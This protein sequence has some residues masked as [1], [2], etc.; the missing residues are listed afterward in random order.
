MVDY[1]S[2]ETKEAADISKLDFQHIDERINRNGNRY[3]IERATWENL[4][5]TCKERI[6]DEGELIPVNATVRGSLHKWYMGNNAGQFSYQDVCDSI[7]LLTNTLKITPEKCR[8]RAIE[9]AVNIHTTFDV[10]NALK[11]NFIAHRKGK[12]P[13]G[14]KEYQTGQMFRVGYSHYQIK[15]YDKGRESKTP[16]NILRIEIRITEGCKHPFIKTL[17]DITRPEIW[18]K[19]GEQILKAM[20]GLIILDKPDQSNPISN[21]KYWTGSF[22]NRTAKQRAFEAL[23]YSRIKAE[24]LQKAFLTLNELTPKGLT[25]D[26]TRYDVTNS[27][28]I[29]ENV[30]LSGKCQVTGI[31]ISG[32]RKGSR[33]AS[34]GTIKELS[35]DAFRSLERKYLKG[36]HR[37]K[38]KGERARL[39][40]NQIRNEG[41]AEKVIQTPEAKGRVIRLDPRIPT[42]KRTPQRTPLQMKRRNP[43]NVR[44]L[45]QFFEVGSGSE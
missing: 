18:H 24:I 42:P 13:P 4:E 33:Y 1:I 3:R 7:Q 37:E 38:S 6:S 10:S 20:N 35:P 25:P 43:H 34:A 41:K 17:A 14:E 19:M 15:C 16:G 26:F 36:R 2:V 44:E 12:T 27:A 30:T 28:H 5:I 11:D 29:P 23:P 32:Q 21:P 45:R 31:D 22:Q 40:A 8:I 39:I 9:Y